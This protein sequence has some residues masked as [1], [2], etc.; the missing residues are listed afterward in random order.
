M[1]KRGPRK[2]KVEYGRTAMYSLYRKVANNPVDKSVHSSVLNDFNKEIS[3][4]IM[5]EAYEYLLPFRLGTL[6]IKKYKAHYKID[7]E[8]GKIAGNLPV[9]WKATNELW[10]N[11]PEAK[12]AKKMV[13]HTNE[14]SN[15]YQYKWNFSN[16]RS[17]CPNKSAYCFVPSRT[18]KRTLA[19]LIKDEDFEGDYY[20]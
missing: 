10:A 20:M 8:T 6:R 19:A 14:H 16:Y 15:G 17:N 1:D 2:N 18:N 9:N 12:E 13:Y 4:A 11:N 5:E 3:K 7:E